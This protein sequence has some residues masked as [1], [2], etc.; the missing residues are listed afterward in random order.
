[1]SGEDDERHDDEQQS[2]DDQIQ[3]HSTQPEAEELREETMEEL[4]DRIDSAE[5]QADDAEDEAHQAEDEAEEAQDEAEEAEEEAE[6]AEDEASGGE[7]G[8]EGPKNPYYADHVDHAKQKASQAWSRATDM[9]YQFGTAC[10][11]VG[12]A[13]II[14]VY[15][16]Y[17][18]PAN[19]Y[20][21]IRYRL[22]MY[23]VLAI[24]SW[25]SLDRKSG[26]GLPLYKAIQDYSILVFLS[27]FFWPIIAVGIGLIGFADQRQ[28]MRYLEIARWL[29][30]WFPLYYL[31]FRGFD[32]E[33]HG[34]RVSKFFKFIVSPVKLVKWS[35]IVIIFASLFS[36][37]LSSPVMEAA[38]QA[39]DQLPAAPTVDRM[40]GPRFVYNTVTGGIGNVFTVTKEFI[41][42]QMNKTRSFVRDPLGSGYQADVDENHLGVEV[43]LVRPPNQ[44]S[45]RIRPGDDASMTATVRLKSEE[46]LVEPVRIRCQLLEDGEVVRKWWEGEVE[47]RRLPMG[48][49][50]APSISQTC[51]FKDV[52]APDLAEDASKSYTARMQA[53][54]PFVTQ[55]YTE[56][57]FVSTRLSNNP[58]R[59]DEYRQQLDELNVDSVDAKTTTGPV[60]LA[61]RNDEVL[62]PQPIKLNP[63]QQAPTRF[64][65]GF[66]LKTGKGDIRSLDKVEMHIP[67]YLEAE[68]SDRCRF[69]TNPGETEGF[70]LASSMDAEVKR[71]YKRLFFDEFLYLNQRSDPYGACNIIVGPE[72]YDDIITSPNLIT[73]ITFSVVAKYD[74]MLS[75]ERDIIVEGATLAGDG[76]GSGDTIQV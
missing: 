20:G 52:Q 58:A 12:L 40:T 64:L 44:G 72:D 16:T 63:D 1:M 31:W 75:V 32:Y 53:V 2:R 57:Y 70:D 36:F 69:T 10:V 54:F 59:R 45:Q 56:Y 3:E 62:T 68:Q 41:T 24:M 30:A 4:H 67:E 47:Q 43:D 38:E 37:A 7:G 51:E 11:L 76:G 74:Y 71:S 13:A 50:R 6:E 5:E 26:Y 25:W 21:H 33:L 46:E 60:T 15:D 29:L 65:Y 73:P 19:V 17:S 22:L 18:L 66:V 9:D 61:T 49:S 34:S 35:Y 28:L 42:M 48:G 8:D 55:A 39:D 27:V 14:H 23:M